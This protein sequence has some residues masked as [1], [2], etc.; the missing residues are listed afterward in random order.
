MLAPALKPFNLTALPVDT[1]TRDTLRTLAL[2]RLETSAE[3]AS[4]SEMNASSAMLA[5]LKEMSSRIHLLATEKPMRVRG[6]PLSLK[7]VESWV[8]SAI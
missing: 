2:S 5:A 6:N 1:Q 4:Q 7:V 8:A 3:D